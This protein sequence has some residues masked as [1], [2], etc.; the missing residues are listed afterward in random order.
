[1]TDNQKRAHDLALIYM[2]KSINA[3]ECSDAM[4]S[5][6]VDFTCCYTDAYLYIHER[7]EQ[8]LIED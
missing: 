2:E 1:M 8:T 7:L 5:K 4:K 6:F 3:R